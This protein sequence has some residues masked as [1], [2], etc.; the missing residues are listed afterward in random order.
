MDEPV[1]AQSVEPLPAAPKDG[2]VLNVG[3]YNC[4]DSTGQKRKSVPGVTDFSSA[5]PQDCTPFLMSALHALPHYRVLERSRV[6]DILKERQLAAVMLG[7]KSRTALGSMVIAD[8][9]LLGQ[10]VSYDRT[11]SQSAG[12][13]AINAVGVAREKVADTFTFSLRAVSTKSGEVLGEVLVQKTVESVQS[14]GHILKIIGVDTH[15]IELGVASNE[16]AGLA[17]Q[18][19]IRL[20]VLSLTRKGMQS[21]WW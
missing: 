6:D 11:T 4:Y 17:L 5:V 14:N 8:V 13:L 16:P 20:A 9:L 2:R 21:G 15:S 10:I 19:A 18:Q 1:P 7:E 12:G 3:I